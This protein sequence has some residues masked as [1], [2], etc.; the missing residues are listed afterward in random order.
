MSTDNPLSGPSDSTCQHVGDDN[1]RFETPIVIND[2]WARSM[3]VCALYC[4][5]V[6]WASVNQLSVKVG[7]PDQGDKV[8]N[9]YLGFIY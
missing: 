2:K 1:W 8:L 3:Q 4:S 6:C 9:F 5:I 7:V